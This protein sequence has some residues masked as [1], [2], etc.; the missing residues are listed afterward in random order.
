MFEDD[1]KHSKKVTLNLTEEDYIKLL[2]LSDR[3]NI[4]ASTVAR[5]LFLDGL[6]S[7]NNPIEKAFNGMRG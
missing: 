3:A 6:D 1:K 4:P 2:E 5:K 7:F